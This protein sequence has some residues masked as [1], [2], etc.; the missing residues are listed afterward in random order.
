[1]YNLRS[2]QKPSTSNEIVYNVQ[3]QTKQN[4]KQKPEPE[5]HLIA[6]FG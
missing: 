3:K 1:M 2:L 6:D 4:G 5:L